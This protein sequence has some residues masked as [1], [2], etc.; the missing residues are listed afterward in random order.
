VATGHLNRRSL[1]VWVF[2]IL[3]VGS[4]L[5]AGTLLDR[6]ASTE[7]QTSRAL[8]VEVSQ[9]EK[10]D[11]ISSDRFYSGTVEAR[12]S[13]DLGFE[14]LGKVSSI[15]V[16]EGQAVE[17]GA[18]LV[19][20]DTRSLRLQ[21][22]QT[23]AQQAEAQARLD[24]LKAGPRPEVIR[25]ARARVQ[26]LLSRKELAQ[27]RL[28]RREELLERRAISKEEFD[29]A[30]FEVSALEA[31][32]E[33]AQYELDE[34]L[35]GTRVEQILSQ[36][37][38]VEQLSAQVAT[39]QLEI[40]KST[41][42][43]PFAGRISERLVDEGRVVGIAEPV[44]S[45]LEDSAPRVKIGLP[46]DVSRDLSPGTPLPIMVGDE[47]YQAELISILP[48]LEGRTRSATALLQIPDT[49]GSLLKSGE[50]ARLKLTQD[51]DISGF[52]LPTSALTRGVR[53]LWSCTVLEPVNDGP[54]SKRYRARRI[55]VEILLSEEDR[56]LV[57]GP[58]QSGDLVVNSGINRIAAGQIVRP[59]LS[60]DGV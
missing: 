9:I 10:V 7:I 6:S 55:D 45:I 8:P 38:V 43:A 57:R 21:L 13:S 33:A 18:P 2:A 32:L 52:W 5:F 53:G 58:L 36:E 26:E 40:E 60:L 46:I 54:P 20:L 17:R 50:V 12:R 51:V 42:R 16:E 56:V 25:A 59:A 41:L 23:Q 22:R 48:E 19:I 39:L 14:R 11:R 27:I 37:A 30:T 3:G 4:L 24:E 15:L 28:L 44:M 1:A 47:S 49:A 34:L 35:A 29:T 31:T